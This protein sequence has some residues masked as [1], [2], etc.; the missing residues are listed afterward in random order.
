M[1]TED[2]SSLSSDQKELNR[3][4]NDQMEKISKQLRRRGYK[5]IV[6]YDDTGQPS[7]FSGEIPSRKTWWDWLQFIIQLLALIAIPVVIAVGTA[8]F[9]NQQNQT[10]LQ[11]AQNNRQND[12]KIADDQQQE[13][14]LKAYL[15]DMTT[16]LLDKKLGSQAVTDQAAVVARERTL[17]TLRRLGADR[18]KIL[19]QFLQYA[20][21]IGVKN[22]VI[23]LSNV[24]LSNDN[25]RGANLRGVNLSG[26][27]LSGAH[28]SG[29]DLSFV[30]LSGAHLS[31][32]DLSGATLLYANLS[33]ADLLKTNLSGADLNDATL[34]KA[35][36]SGADLSGAQLFNADLS[37]ADLSGADL[38]GADLSGAT[39]IQATLSNANLSCL[40]QGGNKVC[41]DLS[42]A[43]LSGADLS[44]A[45][46][47]FA[48]LSGAQLCFA[49][50]RGATVTREQLKKAITRQGA[51][52]PDGSTHPSG[53]LCTW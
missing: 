2:N 36:L 21:L 15:D 16:L 53:L 12:L 5:V 28:L 14:T 22:S 51:I 6:E 17:I 30:D 26:A 32:A 4:P 31:G 11:I 52:M 20:H 1:A 37:G 35:D 40:N 34:L 44:F 9:S 47:S 18:N 27:N 24:D 25:L 48:H 3:P 38:S 41:T 42:G 13:A 33:G 50:L 45:D 46:L 39:L 7:K 23:D 43:H 49:N 8:E 10:S 29:A 19:L